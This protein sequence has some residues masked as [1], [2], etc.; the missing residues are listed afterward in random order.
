MEAATIHAAL[1]LAVVTM[2]ACTGMKNTKSVITL[3]GDLDFDLC[4]GLSDL[5]E[6]LAVFGQCAGE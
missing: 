6:F 5:L 1:A 4:V 3:H 2:K